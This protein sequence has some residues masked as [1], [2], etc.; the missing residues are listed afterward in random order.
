MKTADHPPMARLDTHRDIR[1]TTWVDGSYSPQGTF[2]RYRG[3]RSAVENLTVEETPRVALCTPV[4]TCSLRG[5]ITFGGLKGHYDHGTVP[6]LCLEELHGW[7]VVGEDYGRLAR[8]EMMA[9]LAEHLVFN[10]DILRSG[11]DMVDRYAW[12]RRRS[13]Q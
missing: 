11:L 4:W 3:F 1:F 9:V 13:G 6:T 7:S 10:G 5:S 8:S 2:D 12:I